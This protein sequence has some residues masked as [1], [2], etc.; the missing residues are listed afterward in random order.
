LGTAFTVNS[1]GSVQGGTF[2][3]LPE[4]ILGA[5]LSLVA[6]CAAFIAYA[7]FK[8]KSHKHIVTDHLSLQPC[9]AVGWQLLASM[10]IFFSIKKLRKRAP[11]FGP[12]FHAEISSYFVSEIWHLRVKRFHLFINDKSMRK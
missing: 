5:L 6:C 7:T 1:D 11:N 4:Y 3:A 2:F 9:T 8:K 10:P 12:F